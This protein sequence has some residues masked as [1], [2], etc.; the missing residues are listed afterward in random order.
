MPD[1]LLLADPSVQGRSDHA[2]LYFDGPDR[3][4]EGAVAFLDRGRRIGHRLVYCVE[5]PHPGRLR[6]LEGAD[7]LLSSGGLRLARSADAYGSG[8]RFDPAQ[9]VSTFR[10][11]LDEALRDGYSGL[12]VAADNT[13]QVQGDNEAMAR[14]AEYELVIDRFIAANPVA[15]LCGIDINQ[16]EPSRA[17]DLAIQHPLTCPSVN[18]P[19]RACADGAALK[20]AGSVDLFACPQLGRVLSV[21]PR[22]EELVLDLSD[23]EFLCHNAL[24]LLDGMADRDR[25]IRARGAGPMVR[26]VWTLL[27]LDNP[28]LTLTD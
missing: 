15:G 16:V 19:F 21:A 1:Q 9:Q 22:H 18:V 3:F 8:D 10:T 14:W 12:S 26:R 20:I 28:W 27:G 4:D 13:A 24:L 25:P 7:E 5:D 23:A 6:A 2:A 17:R 11:M